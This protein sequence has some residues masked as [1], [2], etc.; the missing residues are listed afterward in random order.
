MNEATRVSGPAG[1]EAAFRESA[2]C[3][4][5]ALDASGMGSFVWYPDVDRSE[6]DDRMLALF[7]LED[8]GDLSLA[9]ALDRL[10]HP[11][12]RARYEAAVER[13]LDP[14]GD[15]EFREEVCVRRSDGER[16]LEII[17]RVAFAGDPRA[18][19]RMVGFANEVTA[20]KRTEEALRR[21]EERYRTLFESTG[22]GFCILDVLLD[23]DGRPHDYRFVET[24]PAFERHTGLVDAA[25]KTARELVP[26]LEG[27]WVETYGRVALTGESERFVEESTAMGR[28]F[29]V[30]AFRLGDP[31]W[32]RVALLFTD[33]TER[34]R[35]EEALRE[36]E[37]HLRRVMGNMLSF[38]ALTDAAGTLLEVNEPALAVAGITRADVVGK[39]FW[40]GHWWSY[41]PAAS[42]R[43]EDA[44]RRAALGEVIRFD[45]PAR[46]VGDRQ[47]L[48]DFMLAPVRDEHGT[49]RWLVPSGLDITDRRRAEEEV[50]ALNAT[51][52]H[53]VDER[54][55]QVRQLARALTLAEQDERG[56]IAHVLHDDL[57]PTLAGAQIAVAQADLAR[58]EAIL[59]RALLAAR[60]LAHELSPPLLRGDDLAGLLDWLAERVRNEHG[61]VVEVAFQ[62]DVSVP[63]ADLR[64]LLYQVL[65]ELLFNVAK[66]AG[67]GAA[68]IEAERLDGHV[69][70]VVSDD[71]AG[72]DVDERSAGGMGL[73]SVRERL[74]LV[75]GSVD[76][77]SAPGQGTRVTMVIPSADG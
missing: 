11:A 33:I 14:A 10:I 55:A 19:V 39:K 67:T 16:H 35:S 76:V 71:G 12:D 18:P 73:A 75:G 36:S 63:E 6:P 52:E 38:V 22:E 24:N 8:G 25:G 77:A 64:I 3:V 40:E 37:A 44:V 30:E 51:L 60:T 2:E 72:F 17:G 68:R 62:G 5:L 69:R 31:D 42:A 29:E 70:L 74:D 28:W 4:R 13:A 61:V 15:G 9:T 65:R 53:R 34:R 54:T 47:L 59:D 57:Q 41:E 66:H 27:H 1:P 56:R 58:A 50:R 49:I 23:A 43:I 32:R 45:I 48:I 21:S 7:G 20:R 46:A 26:G